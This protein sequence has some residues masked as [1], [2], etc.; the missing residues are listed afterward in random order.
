MKSKIRSFLSN[1]YFIH[2][3]VFFG[4]FAV[5]GF[6]MTSQRFLLFFVTLSFAG[7]ICG[8]LIRI[9]DEVKNKYNHL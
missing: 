7:A 1:V 4:L 3:E 6:I 2:L 9:I 8:S 5:L